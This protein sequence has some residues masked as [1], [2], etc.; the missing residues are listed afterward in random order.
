MYDQAV[1]L[2]GV[3][4]IEDVFQGQRLEVQAVAGVVVGGDGLGIAVDHDRFDAHFLQR[5]RRVAAA[6][7]ELDALSDAVGAAAQYD[8]FLAVRGAGFAGAL[9]IGIEVRREAFELGG[10]GVHAAEDR[11]H[12]QLLAAVA[13]GDLG[14]APRLGHLH[15]GDAVAFGGAECG[16]G[17]VGPGGLRQAGFEIRYFLHLL[18]EPGVDGSEFAD[19]F[20]CVAAGQGEAEIVQTIRRRRY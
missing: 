12:A 2:F 10:A 6:V 16:L 11:G 8:H 15:V 1:G 13:D 18:Q 20:H 3:V 19:F 17:N 5:E 7:I 9:V 4:D 14:G